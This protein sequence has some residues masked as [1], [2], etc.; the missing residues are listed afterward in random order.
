M[1][2]RFAFVALALM[3]AA[4]APRGPSFQ[5]SHARAGVPRRAEPSSRISIGSRPAGLS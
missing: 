4:C 3:L 2:R 5:G 1:I